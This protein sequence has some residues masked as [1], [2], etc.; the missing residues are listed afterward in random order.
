[1]K[2]KK[3][4]SEA[5]HDTFHRSKKHPQEIADELG[6]SYNYLARA[7]LDGASGC[8]FPLRLLIPLMKITG[9]YTVLKRM[10]N[11]CGFLLVRPPRGVKKVVDLQKDLNKYQKGFNAIMTSLIEFIEKPTYEEGQRVIEMLLKHMEET[12]WWRR[13][14]HRNIVNQM[15]LFEE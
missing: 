2:R 11:M 5:L 12:E 3:S 4:I 10:A 13:R 9:D 6:V 7:V 15:E 14:C 8:N 1:M